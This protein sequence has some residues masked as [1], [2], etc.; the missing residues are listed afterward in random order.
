MLK[1]WYQSKTIWVN[2][3]AGLG[4]T[5][6]AKYGFIIGPEFQAWGLTIVNVILRWITNSK[7]TL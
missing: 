3:L 5:L 1:K 4:L 6:Q 2:I 7:I